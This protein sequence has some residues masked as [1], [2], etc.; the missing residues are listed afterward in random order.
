MAERGWISNEINFFQCVLSKSQTFLLEQMNWIFEEEKSLHNRTLPGYDG[1]L[2]IGV[3]KNPGMSIS[4]KID[5][6]MQIYDFSQVL[7]FQKHQSA[8]WKNRLI[9]NVL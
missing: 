9:I 5:I 8:K 1:L 6:L 4:S 7:L 2:E 3:G